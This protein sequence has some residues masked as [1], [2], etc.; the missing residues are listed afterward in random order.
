MV[1]EWEAVLA[2]VSGLLRG[3]AR[4]LFINQ[5][6]SNDV[7]FCNDLCEEEPSYGQK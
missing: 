4:G 1:G 3:R 2:G 7:I 6:N 5:R